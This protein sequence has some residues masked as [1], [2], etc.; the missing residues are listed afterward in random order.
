MLRKMDVHY[1][2]M[3]SFNETTRNM[4]FCHALYLICSFKVERQAQ[5]QKKAENT[6]YHYSNL[7]KKKKKVNDFSEIIKITEKLRINPFKKREPFL[8][9]YY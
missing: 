6:T 1:F 2:L 3:I 9:N 5:K 7:Q 4:D 8:N